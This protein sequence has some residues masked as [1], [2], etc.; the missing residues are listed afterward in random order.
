MRFRFGL[1]LS[2]AVCTM[3][4]H[5]DLLAGAARVSITPDTKEFHYQLGG[6]V[7]KERTGHPATG[8]H[9]TCYARTIVLSSGTTRVAVVSLDL[10]FLPANMKSAVLSR[11]GV[12][13]VKAAG[14]FLAA[15][16]THSAPDP[17]ALHSA[18][19]GKAGDLSTYDPKLADWM[20]DHIAQ[21]INEAAAKLTPAKVGSMQVDKVG[22][23]RNRRG[24]R[25][26]DDQLT[27][28]R[29]VSVDNKPLAEIVNYAAHPVYFGPSM[30]EV[31]G[32]WS[33]SMAR[34]LEAKEPGVVA[35]FLNGAEGDASANG[36]DE[37]TS[38]DKITTYAAKLGIAAYELM[39]QTRL[40]IDAKISCWTQT[41]QLPPRQPHPFFMLAAAAMRATPGQAK[42]LVNQTMP[43]SCEL[44]FIQI[45]PLLLMGFP[46]EPTAAVGL[47][48]KALARE[49]GVAIPAITALT[50]GWL[51]YLVTAEQYKAGKYEP[52]MS[53]YGETIGATILEGVKSGLLQHK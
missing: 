11:I 21:S 20:A 39:M 3:T 24:E 27:V 44:S 37:G 31:S 33:G 13:G 7:A 32:D 42:E 45:G 36:S 25:L 2:L 28:V 43:T 46:G 52:T 48:A 17:L 19:T 5:A 18:N 4:C 30:M 50:N 14:L 23:N 15:T 26:T 34:I 22:L 12:S 51:G 40:T 16:H 47:A 53:F 10:C 35:L 8:I 1:T 49:R 41:V 9:D 6:Y 29:V 38:A